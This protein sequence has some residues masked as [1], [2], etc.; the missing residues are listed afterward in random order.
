MENCNFTNNTA[1][2]GGAI[3]NNYEMN[4]NN[5]IFT[6]NTANNGGGIF[7]NRFML[8]SQNIM[9]DNIATG[10]G[11]AIYNNGNMSVLNLTYINNSTLIVNNNTYLILY[12]TLTDDMGNNITGQ[13]I[14]FY[15]N[16]TFIGNQTVNEGYV[17]VNYLIN[18]GTGIVTVTGD[19]NGH[20]DAG[21]NI[22][23]G[24]L[25]ITNE[26]TVNGT[27]NL[28]KNKYKVNET[29]KGIINI[30]NNGLYTAYEIVVNLHLPN[31]FRLNGNT[32]I[33]S[34][35]YY[36]PNTNKW[37]IGNLEPGEEATMTFTGKFTKA[38]NY[39]LN[40]TTT[41]ENFN[42]TTDSDYVIVTE[43]STPTPTPEPDDNNKTINNPT[44][45]SAMKKTGIPIFTLVL[46][47]LSSLG[48]I[49]RKK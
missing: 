28:D 41:G 24:Q 29:A 4:I 7:N 19:Y 1:N 27:I 49:I 46:L 9:K 30:I 17:S 18:H 48:L 6:N 14:S 12:A 10:L 38:D 2:N 3:Y 44:A 8:V 35:G 25:L 23:T 32:V 39:T 34:H 43:K 36:D 22:N 37:H 21:I 11:S 33:V 5:S 13:N 15:V 26:T 42:N 47:L 16:G 20:N 40:I 31:E 45:N